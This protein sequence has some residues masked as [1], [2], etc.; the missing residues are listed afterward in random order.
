MEQSTPTNFSVQ[1]VTSHE[2]NAESTIAKQVSRMST[3]NNASTF[4]SAASPRKIGVNFSPEKVD[5]NAPFVLENQKDSDS[6]FYEETESLHRMRTLTLAPTLQDISNMPPSSY[7]P[8]Q[9][10]HTR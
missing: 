2:L 9:D 3:D 1:C 4:E 6:S 10:Q 8:R 5:E 7:V